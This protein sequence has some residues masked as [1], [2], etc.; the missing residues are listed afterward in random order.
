MIKNRQHPFDPPLVLLFLL[1]TS[2][3]IKKRSIWFI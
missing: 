1:G 3:H 2:D